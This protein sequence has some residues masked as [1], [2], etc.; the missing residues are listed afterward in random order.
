MR[1]SR[2]RTR[3]TPWPGRGG[4]S[5][6]RA[7]GESAVVEFYPFANTGFIIMHVHGG[8]NFVLFFPDQGVVFPRPPPPGP[9]RCTTAVTRTRWC[10]RPRGSRAATARP[11]TWPRFSASP[12]R[13]GP[14]PLRGEGREPAPKGIQLSS[15]EIVLRKIAQGILRNYFQ[16]CPKFLM[17]PAF[18]T[19][20]KYVPIFFDFFP[21]FKITFFPHTKQ[22]IFK[23]IFSLSVSFVSGRSY[24]VCCPLQV[25]ASGVFF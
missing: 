21:S 15:I 1:S 7:G 23:W 6:T 17:P 4:E 24:L 19:K 12:A 18:W 2:R 9:R 22:R 13:C 3:T 8:K 20:I 11:P 10:G 14:L 25:Q 16:F 5:C